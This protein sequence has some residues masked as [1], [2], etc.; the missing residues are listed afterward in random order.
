[1]RAQPTARSTASWRSSHPRRDLERRAALFARA[2]RALGER[3]GVGRPGAFASQLLRGR[4]LGLARGWDRG[5]GP[6]ALLAC[7][8][9]EQHDLALIAF[10]LALGLEAGASGIWAR[11]RR[12]S[13]SPRPLVRPPFQ[14]IVIASVSAPGRLARSDLIARRGEDGPGVA[15]RLWSEC[16][17]R[18]ESTR[19]PP[20]RRPGGCR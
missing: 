12:W 19:S 2:R 15:R 13:H 11:T 1:M 16:R 14:A 17:A 8:P 6:R 18:E 3:S 20:R 9:G 4:L 5:A 7:A 10:G